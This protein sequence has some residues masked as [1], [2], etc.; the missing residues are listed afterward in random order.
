MR[1]ESAVRQDEL[2]DLARQIASQLKPDPNRSENVLR[3]SFPR[4]GVPR[5]EQVAAM[6]A[7]VKAADVLGARKEQ[8]TIAERR[9]ADAEDKVEALK[10]LLIEA[11]DKLTTTL[12]A[13]ERERKRAED[14]ERRS[15]EM[16]DRTQ[17]MLTDAS[18][19]LN[20][21]EKRAVL[22]EE[23]LSTLQSMIR[24]RFDF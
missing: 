21:S 13:L 24:E 16:L 19:R 3:P 4:P 1:S 12:D 7:V 5:P 6:N 8:I 23:Y 11:E 20:A 10:R 15:A 14:L 22:A 17:A 18:E 9:A 2:N